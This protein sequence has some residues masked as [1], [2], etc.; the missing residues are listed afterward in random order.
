MKLTTLKLPGCGTKNDT[1]RRLD[2]PKTITLKFHTYNKVTRPQHA[3]KILEIDRSRDSLHLLTLTDAPPAPHSP[4]SPHD[5]LLLPV[6][7]H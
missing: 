2:S 5:A 4:P 6:V 3:R 7:A 1:F